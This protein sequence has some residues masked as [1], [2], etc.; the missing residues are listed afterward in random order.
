MIPIGD[1]RMFKGNGSLKQGP[2]ATFMLFKTPRIT[3]GKSRW[4]E[5]RPGGLPLALGHCFFGCQ[6]LWGSTLKLRTRASYVDICCG[7]QN[8]GSLV[9]AFRGQV[10]YPQAVWGWRWSKLH[11]Q[12]PGKTGYPHLLSFRL[13]LSE[14]KPCIVTG[15]PEHH[16]SSL[17]SY[18][19]CRPS[20]FCLSPSLALSVSLKH[21]MSCQWHSG[22][23]GTR[24]MGRNTAFLSCSINACQAT[25]EQGWWEPVSYKPELT[26]VY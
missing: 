19:G 18:S 15:V 6:C 4:G 9:L 11:S 3:Q 23:Q 20:R 14:W 16:T 17:S 7:S 2:L 25:F 10:S 21:P 5:G 8:T 26:R 22:M 1:R 12:D 13:H 24:P